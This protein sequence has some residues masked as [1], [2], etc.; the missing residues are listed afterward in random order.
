MTCWAQCKGESFYRQTEQKFA[1]WWFHVGLP[2]SKDL[3]ILGHKTSV[4]CC[5]F[6]VYVSF[7][8]G[9][10]FQISANSLVLKSFF[11]FSNYLPFSLNVHFGKFLPCALWYSILRIPCGFWRRSVRSS[12]KTDLS[13]RYFLRYSSG[14]SIAVPWLQI[15][16]IFGKNMTLPKYANLN[17][18]GKNSSCWLFNMSILWCFL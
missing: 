10:L 17:F 7:L 14:I 5:V 13:K 11:V 1:L 6:S 8:N 15:I 16:S 4:H 12:K 9:S 18:W 3:K 2:K